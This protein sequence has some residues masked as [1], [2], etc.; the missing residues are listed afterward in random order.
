MLKKGVERLVLLGV[1]EV[2][3][4]SEWVAPSFAQPKPK[5][6]QVRFLSDFINLNKQLN[7]NHTLYQ[8]SMRCYLN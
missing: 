3:N 2:A 6:N 4:Y 1:L 5:S 8:K 7:R